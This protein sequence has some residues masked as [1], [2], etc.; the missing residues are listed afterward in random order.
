MTTL[1]VQPQLAEAEQQL[2]AQEAALVQQLEDIREKRQGLQTVIDLFD[3]QSS[4]SIVDATV[5]TSAA[6]E[7]AAAVAEAE[8]KSPARATKAAQ[9]TQTKS[10]KGTEKLKTKKKV[11]GR[12][13]DWQRYIR[14]EYRDAPLPEVVESILKAMKDSRFKI[15]E[16]MAAIFVDDMP[17]TQFLKARNRISNILSGGA[18]NGSWYRGRGGTYSASAKAV[19]G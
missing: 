12:A 8:S 3:G 7:T 16:V 14:D 11:D 1:S 4:L 19:K 13:A 6:D 17:K 9:N 15:A 5:E 2:A 10:K 18:R